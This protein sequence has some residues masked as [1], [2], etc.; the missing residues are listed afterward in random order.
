MKSFEV[1]VYH[2]QNLVRNVPLTEVVTVGRQDVKRGEPR[3]VSVHQGP[4][5]HRLI[6]AGSNQTGVPRSWFTLSPTDDGDLEVENLHSDYG[7]DV[8]GHRQLACGEKQSFGEEFVIDLGSD[9]AVRVLPERGQRLEALS[10]EFRTLPSSVPVPGSDWPAE[11]SMTIRQMSTDSGAATVELLKVALQ[12]VQTAAGSDAFFQSAVDATS[13]MVELERAI[14]LMRSD[15][16]GVEEIA[17]SC[18]LPN[19]WCL[20]AE[21]FGPDTDPTTCPAVSRTILNRVDSDAKATVIHDPSRRRVFDDANSL[22]GV[23]CAVASPILN[24]KG[25]VIGVLYGDRWSDGGGEHQNQISEVEATLVEVLAGAV[26]GGM[27]RKSEEKRR[28]N[29]S[30]FFSPRV[31]DLLASSPK[32]LQGHDAEVSVLFCDIRG[33]S[34]VTEKLGPTKT[35]EWINDVLSELSQCVVDTDGVLVDYV[36]DELMAMWGAPGEQPDHAKRAVDTAVAM[37]QA[38]VILRERWA[39]VLPDRFGAGIGVNTGQARVGNVGSKWKFKYGVLGNTVNVGSRLQA[40]TKQLQ[41][42]C[43]I[44]QRSATESGCAERSRRLAKLAVVGIEE[45]IDVFQIASHPDADWK[46]LVKEYET[47]LADFESERFGLAARRLGE[48]IQKFPSDRPSRQLLA[49]AAEQLNDP[50][51]SFSPVWKLSKK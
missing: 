32:M 31:A 5:G 38:I 22:I 2:G 30:G 36:G 27:A 26:A 14:V 51:E 1:N 50:A 19:G 3:P 25:E 10:E 7:V 4:N 44:S 24:G 43:M 45:P 47:A 18:T 23:H 39:D 20:V 21:S 41:V 8:Q 37:Q 11:Q 17:M 49:R 33:F 12:V 48:L 28:G 46:S 6:V 40:A 13:R 16:I 34:V 9:I 29:L 35:I 15:A 42:D